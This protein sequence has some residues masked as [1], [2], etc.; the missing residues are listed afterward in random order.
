MTDAG[1]PPP[2]YDT[3]DAV[4]GADDAAAA[5]AAAADDPRITVVMKRAAYCDRTDATVTYTPD[6]IV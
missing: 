3:I 2:A 5:A 4:K 1:P 6:P